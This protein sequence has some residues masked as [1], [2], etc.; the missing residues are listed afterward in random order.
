MEKLI[1]EIAGKD[2]QHYHKLENT[3]VSIG[4][5]LDND[6]IL[7][8][9]TVSPHHALIRQTNNDHIEIRSLANENGLLIDGRRIETAISVKE[10]P[11]RLQL[12]RVQARLLSSDNSVADT[13]LLHCHQG[14]LCLFHS[15]FWLAFFLLLVVLV[16]ATDHYLDTIEKF[17]WLKLSQATFTVFFGLG[18]SAGI[19]AFVNR[20]SVQR[21]EYRSALLFSC[22]LY[23]FTTL[24]DAG[25]FFANYFLTSNWPGIIINL[26]WALLL[27]PL[28][29]FFFLHKINHHSRIVAILVALSFSTPLAYIYLNEIN[30]DQGLWSKFSKSSNYSHTLSPWDIRLENSISIEQFI[31]NSRNIEK[32]TPSNI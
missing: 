30:D 2:L 13:R 21:W 29:L 16:G 6:I 19:L 15:T 10:L 20:L 8:D 4:R 9:T 14:G 5:S 31:Q 7:S 17:D 18:I 32:I 22:I 28:A 1:L 11:V 3:L 26:G 24:T 23:L 25:I 27:L 12:G